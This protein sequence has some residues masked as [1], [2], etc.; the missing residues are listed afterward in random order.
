M[1]GIRKE[2]SC[3]VIPFSLCDI[4]LE[5]PIYVYHYFGKIYIFRISP[6][7]VNIGR[8][9]ALACQIGYARR[10][11]FI[12]SSPCS[13]VN[14]SLVDVARGINCSCRNSMRGIRKETSCIVI[15]F[16]LCDIGLEFPI[17]VYHYFGKIYIFRISP[18]P[19]NI[20][21]S[22]AY[23]FQIGYACRWSNIPYCILDPHR[24]V[25]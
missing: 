22:I 9:I 5:F 10:R 2:T 19:V 11:Y 20:G 3:I 17:Y 25:A 7:P 21:R 14:P 24:K 1:R 6:C 4:G 12:P 23:V 16:S 15:P 13:M 8:S 18:C